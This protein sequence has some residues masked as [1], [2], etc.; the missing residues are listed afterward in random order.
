[1]AQRTQSVPVSLHVMSSEQVLDHIVQDVPRIQSFTAVVLEYELPEV[2]EKR[3]DEYL[4]GRLGSL[5]SLEL[6]LQRQLVS[7]SFLR[8]RITIDAPH[9]RSLYLENWLICDWTAPFF[10]HLTSLRLAFWPSASVHNNNVRFSF[11]EVLHMLRSSPRL[12]HLQLFGM[13]VDQPRTSIFECV[14]LPHLIELE[15]SDDLVTTTC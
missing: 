8:S 7:N 1:M 13:M 6:R 9:L 14:K 12:Q 4:L 15:L 2:A 11:S 5:E 3:I 10:A